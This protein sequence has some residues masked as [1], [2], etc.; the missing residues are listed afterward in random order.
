MY[1]VGLN[2]REEIIMFISEEWKL[3]S[4]LKSLIST[5]DAELGN[6]HPECARRFDN[7]AFQSEAGKILHS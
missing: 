4:Y 2:A 3:H 6:R 7:Q 5:I 1:N